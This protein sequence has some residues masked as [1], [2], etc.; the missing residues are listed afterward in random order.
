MDIVRV[1]PI[2]SKYI[3]HLSAGNLINQ[4]EHFVRFRQI[5][6]MSEFIKIKNWCE[7]NCRDLVIFRVYCNDLFDFKSYS[8]RVWFKNQNDLVLF[9]LHW[10]DYD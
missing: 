5:E 10:I 2:R 7:E 9:G 1:F 8:P 4:A 3:L 6:S